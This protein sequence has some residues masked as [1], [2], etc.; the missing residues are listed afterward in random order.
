MKAQHL[1]VNL[2][3]MGIHIENHHFNILKYTHSVDFSHKL[4]NNIED[5]YLQYANT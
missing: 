2:I 5:K 3:K 4:V 1:I